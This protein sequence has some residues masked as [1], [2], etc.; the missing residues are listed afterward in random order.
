[1][2]RYEFSDHVVYFITYT[3]IKFLVENLYYISVFYILLLSI[4]IVEL[5]MCI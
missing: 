2:T 4:K 1:M 3:C 5:S